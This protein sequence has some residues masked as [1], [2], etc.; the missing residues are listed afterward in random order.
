MEQSAAGG[1][2]LTFFEIYAQPFFEHILA[3]EQLQRDNV[4]RGA[5]FLNGLLPVPAPSGD[6]SQNDFHQNLTLQPT[7]SRCTDLSPQMR[8]ASNISIKSLQTQSLEDV[9][10]W[11]RPRR[12]SLIPNQ[13]V[14]TSSAP[15]TGGIP[16]KEKQIQM[17]PRNVPLS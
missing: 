3:C 7:L 14:T 16:R 17:Y 12:R 8:Y 13:S 9:H 2:Y 6:N 5:G 15:K 4:T 1:H 10:L 11:R